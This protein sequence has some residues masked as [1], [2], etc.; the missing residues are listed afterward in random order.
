MLTSKERA[1]LRAQANG[2]DTTLMVGKGGVTEQVVLEAVTQ[3]EARELV[4]G[5]VLEAAL[6]GAR[7]A[8]E[9]LCAATGAEPVCTVGSKFVL[10]RESEKLRRAR[11]QV[12]RAKLAPVPVA[13]SNPVRKGAQA[14]RRAAQAER[15]RRNAYFRQTAIDRAIQREKEK[16]MGR[17]QP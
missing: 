15:E 5:R 13:K 7:E 9:A 2:L 17:E 3:L 1:E 10:Y 4:K 16:A 12:G 14:R 8:L 11:N 6:L